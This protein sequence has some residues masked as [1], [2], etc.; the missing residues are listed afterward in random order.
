MAT[1]KR[2]H[3]T[4][5]EVQEIL[6]AVAGTVRFDGQQTLTDAQKTQAK[7]NIGADALLIE[8]EAGTGILDFTTSVTYQ[9]A[10]DA[11]RNKRPI[12]ASI[13]NGL[14]LISLT[15]S[16]GDLDNDDLELR[17]SVLEQESG[18]RG[19]GGITIDAIFHANGDPA[20]IKLEWLEFVGAPPDWDAEEYQP[21]YI[22]NKPDVPSVKSGTT[23]Y[24]AES[25]YIPA[26][27]EIIVYTDKASK[28]VDGETV[29]IP[30]IKV[31]SG[32]AYVSDLVFVGDD[33]ADSLHAHV[34]DNV[35]HIT[36][37]ERLSWSDKLNVDDNFEVVN[38]VLI[39]NRN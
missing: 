36:M 11:V 27:G 31:G 26:D 32:N 12:Y 8:L 30:G 7:R 17:G 34:N 13:F 21:G 33:V 39:F 24:W 35:R 9:E 23:A 29:Y 3:Q 6:D 10:K 19:I 15:A 14:L 1:K 25:G 16:L 18:E 4:F 28:I 2:L 22:A 37:A 20:E 38:G 5:D